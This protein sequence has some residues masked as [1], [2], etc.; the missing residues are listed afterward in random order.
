LL[1]DPFALYRPLSEKELR[2][3]LD[4]SA[5]KKLARQPDTM[6]VEGPDGKT[7]SVDQPAQLPVHLVK[8]IFRTIQAY[9][10]ILQRVVD[11]DMDDEEAINQLKA[12]A[13]ELLTLGESRIQLPTDLGAQ[14]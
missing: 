5:L 8:R 1:G 9:H 4:P 7:Y 12:D 13:S 10:Q 14:A 6:D 11:L 3:Y 2:T